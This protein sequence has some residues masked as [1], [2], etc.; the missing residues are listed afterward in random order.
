[1]K[2]KIYQ[3]IVI[4]IFLSILY[5]NN[6]YAETVSGTCGESTTWTF[7]T[8]TG[9]LDLQGSGS[10]DS[11]RA[12]IEYINQI[13]IIVIGKDIQ[14]LKLD[15]NYRKIWYEELLEFRVENG[16]PNYKSIDGVLFNIDATKLI[17]FPQAKGGN[18]TIPDKVE[19]IAETAFNRCIN[20]KE[21]YFPDSVKYIGFESFFN[22]PNLN[23]VEFGNG[24]LTIGSHAFESCQC[25]ESI[26]I[27]ESV[28]K[29]G[30]YAF[31]YCYAGE[32]AEGCGLKY[33]E[34]KGTNVQTDGW[35]FHNCTKLEKVKTAT[36]GY[37]MFDGCDSLREVIL[38][39]GIKD[40]SATYAFSGEITQIVIPPS[41]ES[42]SGFAFAQCKKLKTIDV[43]KNSKFIVKDGALF[44]QEQTELILLTDKSKTTYTIPDTVKVIGGA[45]FYNCAKLENVDIPYGVTEM[46]ARVFNNCDSLK[47]LVIPYGVESLAGAVI[48]GRNLEYI[49]IPE[50]VTEFGS[51]KLSTYW[52]QN[53]SIYM[54][55]YGYSGSDV[56]TQVGDKFIAI[57]SGIVVTFD[58][59]DG[60]SSKKTKNVYPTHNYGNLPN[61]SRSGYTFDGWYTEV[62]GGKKITENT[63][64]NVIDNQTL[65]AHWK[66]NL[67]IA[68]A[69]SASSVSV[70]EKVTITGTASGGT[71]SYTYSYLVHNK[72]TNQWSRLTSSFTGS[73]SYTWTA[74][75]AGN[76]EFF[77]EV[78][79]STGTVVRSSALNVFVTNT[80]PLAISAKSSASTITK[81]SK[82]TITGTASGGKGSYT[83]SYL[84][85]NKDTNA[86]SRL[87]SAFTTSNTYT[88]TAGSTGNR[89]F[90]VEVKDSAGKVVRSS[91]VN[92]KVTNAELKITGKSNASTVSVGKK[93]TLTGTASG[94]TGS[95]TYSYLVH[96]KDTNQWSRLTSS[97]TGSNNYTWTAG[98]TGN[99]E[100]FVEVK[101]STG[102][103]VRSK[104]INVS[105]TNTKP[106]AITAKSSA[107]TITKGSKVTFTGTASGGKGGYTY[108]Y[109]VHNKDTNAWSRLTSSFTASNTYTW[110]AGSTGNREFFVEVKDSTGKVVRSSAVNVVTK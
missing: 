94:G 77:V 28:E 21:V 2:Q 67:N 53:D 1:M 89:E 27:P 45:A 102:K 35:V 43:S 19:R 44:N 68:V 15:Y 30:E 14:S 52:I 37:S 16:N 84:V 86:W 10:V 60:S 49:V 13:K 11:D 78:K 50:S 20:L 61:P 64:V 85:H 22:C 63:L 55:I 39:D 110:T 98:S 99:R 33:V 38:I 70:G 7:D 23:T 97:F 57:D 51:V 41:V 48:G 4:G 79:D 91:A 59:N 104:A 18:Y 90:F 80:K 75:S 47:S 71:G 83:Y 82:V 54:T 92:V 105:V 3:I 40:V 34:I 107:S 32:W 109:L 12:W 103:V 100:F 29:I 56:E 24:L 95:Y 26:I 58:V 81:G 36:V 42:I 62:E 66:K 65:Y 87:T 9:I 5:C 96:N 46:Q 72:D 93:V 74:G 31:A 6:A 88:W 69:S 76:R 25:L 8:D 17:K 101:D 73:N 108:S 106:L